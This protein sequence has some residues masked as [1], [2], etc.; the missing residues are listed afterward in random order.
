MPCII[1]DTH[2]MAPIAIE[3]CIGSGKS[4]TVDLLR[5]MSGLT[6]RPEPVDKWSPFLEEAYANRRGHVALQ[7]RIMLDTCCTV[8][9]VDIVERSPLLQ[10][11]TFIPVMAD[12]GCITPDEEVLLY[13]LHEKLLTW[14]PDG[15]IFL[16][17]SLP[18]ARRRVRWRA[19]ECEEAID[20]GYLGTL[21]SHY[22]DALR[23]FPDAIVIDTTDLLPEDVAKECLRAVAQLRGT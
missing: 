2:I 8:P 5:R 16:R 21:H 7:A 6:V 22:E 4:T 3:G 9:P 17:C 20:D 1:S 12:T 11:L 13:D 19:R 14:R 23:E 10:P 18:E 15:M